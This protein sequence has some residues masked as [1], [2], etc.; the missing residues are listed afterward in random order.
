MKKSSCL[1]LLLW[2]VVFPVASRAQSQSPLF[3]AVAFYS[4]DT[5]GDHVLFAQ[6]ALKFFSSLANKDNFIFDSTT[7][8][9]NLNANYL[10]NYQLVLWLNGSPTDP[11]QRSAFERYMRSGGAWLGFHASG[12]NDK[13]TH[14]P[15][16]V[17]FLGGAVF[18]ANSWPPLPAQLVW[19]TAHIQPLTPCPI[20][21]S[22]LRTSGI[23][24]SPV[25]ASTRMSACFSR[26]IAATTRWDSKI[27]SRPAI[28][29]SHGPTANSKWS[30]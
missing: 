19:M 9:Q 17:D 22:L 13:D 5:E 12:Y 24:G 2:A 20:S 23:S 30:I 18:Y 21:T 16:Y 1:I 8:W 29:P 3:R 10:R 15:W 27:F 26:L 4:T 6:D 11:E 28:S 7:D 25:R 14:W